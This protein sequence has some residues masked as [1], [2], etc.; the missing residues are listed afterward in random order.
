[1]EPIQ[2]N[3]RQLFVLIVLFEHGSA[4]VIPLGVSAKQDVW[5]AIL[6][7]L[8]LGLLVFSVYGRLFRCYPDQPLVGYIQHIVGAPLGKLLGIVYVTYFLYI[9]ARVL[10]DFGELLLT[11]AYP[12]TPLFVLNAIMALVVMYGAYKGLEVLARTGELFLAMLYVM[13]LAG[14]VLVF[15]SGVMDLSQLEP[16][17]EEGWGRVWKTVFTET[18]YVPFGEMIVF[19]MLFPYV[20]NPAKVSRAAVIGM[21]LTGLNLAVIAA[22]NMIVLGPDGASRSSFPLLDT[23]RRI[24]VAHFFERLDVLFMIAL[25]IGGFFKISIFFYAGVVGAAHLFGISKHQRIVYPLG[26]LVL[27]LSIAIASNYA[28]HIYEGLKIVTFYL[29]IPLQIIIPVLL[30]VIAA[31][32]RRFGPS[33]K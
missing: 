14:F 6:L 26:L 23:I 8:A 9:A 33:T 12:E 4:I 28:E 3:I 5:I 32:R 15:V 17:L 2:I 16:V 10:R 1:M 29:H 21:A 27:L 30:L 19:T 22:I 11:F 25:I 7:G 13:A 20:N 24:Q 18:L 31:I